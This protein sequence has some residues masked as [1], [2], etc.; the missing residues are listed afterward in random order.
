MLASRLLCVAYVAWWCAW[1]RHGVYDAFLLAAECGGL[2]VLLGLLEKSAGTCAAVVYLAVYWCC[3]VL[4]G[5]CACFL[6]SGVLSLAAQGGCRVSW[7]GV[8][9]ALFTAAQQGTL[10]ETKQ[11]RWGLCALALAAA[12]ILI[13][14]TLL[15]LTLGGWA[16][17]SA[18]PHPGAVPWLADWAYPID[19]A[20]H[21]RC[22][23]GWYARFGGE[24]KGN[25]FGHGESVPLLDMS[26]H[27]DTRV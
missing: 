22:P 10:N 15:P 3:S 21:P 19:D 8:V 11:R 6:L 24:R 2:W 18:V 14:R 27:D 16:A 13:D 23:D 5:A 26:F 25:S 1:G 9:V 4:L 7:A 12:P 17:G 20:V